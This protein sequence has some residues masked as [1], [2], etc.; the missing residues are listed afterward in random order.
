MELQL[1]SVCYFMSLTKRFISSLWRLCCCRWAFV[2][3][4]DVIHNYP[5]G[6]CLSSRVICTSS[7]RLCWPH[8]YLHSPYLRSQK[9]SKKVRKEHRKQEQSASASSDSSVHKQ[10]GS[11]RA[12]TGF[13]RCWC[14]KDVKHVYFRTLTS[15]Y[16]YTYIYMCSVCVCLYVCVESICVLCRVY[17]MYVK[18]Q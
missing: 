18:L 13:S 17:T 4:S 16:I 1:G 2:R 11:E 5:Y 7:V 12:V 10:F 3:V 8:L 15:I 9:R 6:L 14:G